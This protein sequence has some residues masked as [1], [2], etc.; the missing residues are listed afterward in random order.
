MPPNS[1]SQVTP[2]ERQLSG[3]SP[4]ETICK[5]SYRD[6][7]AGLDYRASIIV[8]GQED[9]ADPYAALAA[10]PTLLVIQSAAD[11][12]NPLLLALKLYGDIHQTDRWF[13][14]LRSAHHLWS[15]KVSAE[16][17]S[18][19]SDQGSRFT[20]GAFTKMLIDAEVRISMD[21]VGRA[22]DNVFIERLWRT[23]KYDHIY[24]C[25][26][27]NGTECRTGIGRFLS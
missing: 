22:I 3:C 7:R 1:P 13:L 16:P 19:H 18:F 8:S 23:L 25:P 14:E 10:S 20:S 11:Q 4:R 12:C 27:N 9:G 6:L 5:E 15:V 2:T 21:G 24:L 26:A 17:G